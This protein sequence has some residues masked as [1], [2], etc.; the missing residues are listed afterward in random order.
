MQDKKREYVQFALYIGLFI[1]AG[2][3]S[4]FF[5][6]PAV[7]EDIYRFAS[8]IFL[9]FCLFILF[10]LLSKLFFKKWWF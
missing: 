3:F 6:K 2:L 8:F 7:N 9:I 1:F 5:I 4:R 10:P